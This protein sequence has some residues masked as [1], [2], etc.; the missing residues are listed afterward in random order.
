ME[1]ITSVGLEKYAHYHFDQLSGGMT[2]RA[3]LARAL[4]LEPA[5]VLYDEPCSGQDPK[6]A[7]LLMKLIS[8]FNKKKQITSIIISHDIERT[9]PL[10]ENVIVI[11]NGK[12]I[13]SGKPKTIINSK[14]PEIRD[15]LKHTFSEKMTT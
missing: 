7:N 3:A 11:M 14:I 12:M 8:D 1:K 2:K 15:F 4:A 9:L 5:V 6:N 13:A 10:V